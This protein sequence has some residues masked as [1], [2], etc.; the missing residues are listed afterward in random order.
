[1]GIMGWVTLDPNSP[2][3]QTI[4]S[5]LE[6]KALLGVDSWLG[7]LPPT[8]A[9][10]RLANWLPWSCTMW[11]CRTFRAMKCNGILLRRRLKATQA[12]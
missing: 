3:I 12:A 2:Y 6:A 4:G 10:K 5:I 8:P 9:K 11:V 1:V 7:N